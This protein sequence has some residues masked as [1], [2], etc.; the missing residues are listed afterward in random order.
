MP[1]QGVWQLRRRVSSKNLQAI[2]LFKIKFKETELFWPGL[3][4]NTP[5]KWKLFVKEQP[6]LNFLWIVSPSSFATARDVTNEWRQIHNIHK[7]CMRSKIV[8]IFHPMGDAFHSMYSK[9]FTLEI[10][11]HLYVFWIKIRWAFSSTF[12]LWDVRIIC[13]HFHITTGILSADIIITKSLLGPS[14]TFVTA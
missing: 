2:L 12:A 11:A 4:T 3:W 14:R 6:P 9:V 5:T 7:K 10:I 1:E 8:L 13:K